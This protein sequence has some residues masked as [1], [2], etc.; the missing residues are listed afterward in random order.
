MPNPKRAL[1]TAG[2]TQEPIDAVRYLGNRSSGRLG[3]ALA[4]EAARQ[5]W[6]TTLLLGATPL[7]P[8]HPAVTVRRFRTTED[9]QLLL[10][11]EFPPADLLVMA[12]AVADFRPA[13]LVEG[14]KIKR[15]AGGLTIQLESTPDLLAG[16]A[17][18]RRA[19]Q[20]LI[21]F[22]LEPE[23]R[24]LES[25]R[26]KLARKGVDAIVANPLETMDSETIR[27]MIIRR[28]GSAESTSGAVSKQDFARWL[29]SRVSPLTSA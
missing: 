12:A 21:G 24:L 22:A 26:E 16:C 19:G 10:N 6:S 18:A 9:L 8:S 2:P 1:I 28:D 11:E 15:S 20:V 4:D 14:G 23:D 5:G 3:I 13:R 7:A 17:A 27:A 29:F 25:A